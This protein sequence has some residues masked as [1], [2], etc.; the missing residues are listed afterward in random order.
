M[1]PLLPPLG[2]PVDTVLFPYA[3]LVA[4]PNEVLPDAPI[5]LQL[6]SPTPNIFKLGLYE[7]VLLSDLTVLLTPD[8]PPFSPKYT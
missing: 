2:P 3:L 1:S 4:L 8:K 5:I 6:I 7:K